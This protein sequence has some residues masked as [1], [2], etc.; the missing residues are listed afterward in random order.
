M[1]TFSE[2]FNLNKTQAEIDFVDI[3]LEIDTPLYID[4]YALTTREDD[5]SV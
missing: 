2:F 5:W 4:P 1:A 3:D